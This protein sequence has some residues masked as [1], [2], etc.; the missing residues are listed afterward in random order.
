MCFN[1]SNL[2]I[3]NTRSRNK[4]ARFLFFKQYILQKIESY[5]LQLPSSVKPFYLFVRNAKNCTVYKLSR[6]LI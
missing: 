6:L 4:K 5:A 1:I 3:K 2:K